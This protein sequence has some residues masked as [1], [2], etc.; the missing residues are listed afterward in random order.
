M[1]RP[2]RCA[3]LLLAL[4]GVGACGE[5]E[6]QAPKPAGTRAVARP[7]ETGPG[8]VGSAVCAGCHA[9]EAELWSGSHHDRAM[10]VADEATVLGDFADGVFSH[11]GRTSRFARKGDRFTVTTDGPDGQPAEY[12][13]AYTFGFEPLQQY[14]VAMPGGRFQALGIAWQGAD[15]GGEGR[16]FHLYPDEPVPHDD[17]L[18]WTR[19]AQNWNAMCADCHS[20]GVRRGYSLGEDRYE[21]TWAEI[22]VACEACHGPGSAHVAWAEGG[23]GDVAGRGLA[24]DLAGDG[25][26]WDFAPGQPI[27]V[28]SRPRASDAELDA[29]ARCHSRRAILRGEYRWGRPLLDTHRPALLDEG[30]YYAD[31]QIRDEVYVW[32]S[33]VQSRMHAAGVTCSDC[34]DPHALAIPDPPDAVCGR[35][36]APRAFA[37]PAHHHH[38]AGSPGASCVECHMPA[39]TYMVVD[40][41]RDHGFRVPRPDL[42]LEIATPNACTGCHADRDAAWAAAAAERWWG[43]ARAAEPHFGQAI[44]AGRRRLAGAAAALAEL[45]ADGDQPAIARATALRLLRDNPAPG[46][47]E[48][49]RGALRDPDPLVRMAAVE[50]TAA[51]APS[52]RLAVA[53]PA[54]RDPV[55]GVRVEAARALAGLP[56]ELVGSRARAELSAAL[57]EYRAVQRDQADRPEAHLSLGS[58]HA[59]LGELEEA[60]AEY[61]IALR[62]APWFVPTYVNLADLHRLAGRDDEA[63]RVLRRGLAAAPDAAPLH[64][65]L[66]LALVRRQR[67]AEALSALERAAELAPEQPRYAYVHGVALHSIGNVDRALAVLEAALERS[68]A[69]RELLTALATISRDA[70]RSEDARRFAARLVEVSPEDPGPR[71]LLAELESD[72][73]EARP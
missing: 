34:H 58:L 55:L 57:A 27:A 54:L 13:I 22:D 39:R 65:S 61:E 4:A 41:R 68:P 10:E 36:H 52:E 6:V 35:C 63:E 50:T 66:G 60:R 1:R 56:P 48:L 26:T 51:L 72:A 20:T 14:L 45:V 46:V 53:G 38:P 71:R 49:L 7:S 19:P 73:P 32:G 37:T 2:S 31:G 3:A 69:D 62:L 12:E 15:A 23:A 9:R 44:H 47:P 40:P 59:R 42:S 11:F 5:R 21:T 17:V 43:P 24:V 28:R 64:H 67:T 70:G 30:L 18:H 16:W 33:F 25:A 8:F 29:C